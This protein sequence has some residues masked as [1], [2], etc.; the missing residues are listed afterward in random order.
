VPEWDQLPNINTV[1]NGDVTV[2]LK[3]N[4]L[5]ANAA[6]NAAKREIGKLQE[7]ITGLKEKVLLYFTQARNE[8]KKNVGDRAIIE[9]ICPYPLKTIFDNDNVKAKIILGTE[10]FFR[11]Y[12]IVDVAVETVDG[13][14]MLYRI[15]NLHDKIE[16]PPE[17]EEI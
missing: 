2:V 5:E 3:L 13:K 4:A 16:K 11:F 6:Q 10:N 15:I 7:P 14:P 1:I 9:S 17:L 8:P 12:Y